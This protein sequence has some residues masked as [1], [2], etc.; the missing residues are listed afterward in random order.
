MSAKKRRVSGQRGLVSLRSRLNGATAVAA[1]IAAL[2]ISAA[3]WAQP[4]TQ[5]QPNA[6]AHQSEARQVKKAKGSVSRAS[7]PSASPAAGSSATG[8]SATGSSTVAAELAKD[9]KSRDLRAAMALREKHPDQFDCKNIGNSWTLAHIASGAGQSKVAFGIYKHLLAA[10]TDEH[11]RIQTIVLYGSAGGYD[12]AYQLLGQEA[13]RVTAQADLDLLAK[14]VTTL[15]IAHFTQ[16]VYGNKPAQARALAPRLA[17]QIA[18]THNLDGTVA[19]GWLAMKE[20]LPQSAIPWFSRA[21]DQ[22][23]GPQMAANLAQAYMAAGQYDKAEQ[24]VARYAGS[25]Q[26]AAVHRSLMFRQAQAAYKAGRYPD[27]VVL[28]DSARKQGVQSPELDLMRAWSLYHLGRPDA[29]DSFIEIATRNGAEPATADEAATGMLYSMLQQCAAP[30]A[31][32]GPGSHGG[33]AD[34]TADLPMLP[35]TSTRTE[36]DCLARIIDHRGKTV[37]DNIVNAF[38]QR[39]L[40]GKP[41]AKAA[42]ALGWYSL[43]T[44]NTDA[45]LKWFSQGQKWGQDPETIAQAKAGY[46]ETL[47][48]L[49]RKANAEK[50]YAESNAYLKAAAA[51]APA[52]GGDTLLTAW[53][54]YQLHN[55]VQARQGFQSVYAKQQDTKS[56]AGLLAVAQAQNDLSSLDKLPGP[57]HPM[58]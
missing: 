51:I 31:P 2:G 44:G 58:V 1:G 23:P 43:Q 11:D 40:H 32:T 3:S 30:G 39:L 47:R 50:R 21:L 16:L 48:G 55:Y 26:L 35:P 56:A 54:N 27:V 38:A 17:P 29:A 15:D 8:G 45:A 37:V 25:P 42:V 53:N 49:A 28:A 57:N 22:Q 9:E 36:P 12:D 33:I 4:S 20:N 24:L 18:A 46:A 14:S 52:D 13:S 19:L 10:C 6:V 5:T 7:A 41:D 34:P